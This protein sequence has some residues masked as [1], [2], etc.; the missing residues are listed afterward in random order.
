MEGRQSKVI[1]VNG[2]FDILHPG[3][4]ALLEHARN[5]GD[6]LIVGIDRDDRVRE[7]KGP[8]RP[9]NSADIRMI[10]LKKLRLIDRVV[11][12]NSDS[13]LENWIKVFKP[14]IMVVGSDYIGKKIIG[15]EWANEVQ[16][17]ERVGDYSTTKIIQSINEKTS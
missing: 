2:T 6:T 5:L 12:F 9:V 3:H 13:E 15:S 16:Y 14:E 17:F 7:L 8:T 10:N 11:T 1:W 4:L